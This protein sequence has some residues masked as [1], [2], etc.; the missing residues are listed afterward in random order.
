[1]AA[2]I[3]RRL[4]G[5]GH[6]AYFA[7]GCVR[8][9]LLGREPKDYD[10]ATDAPPKRVRELF[11]NTQ[12]VGEHFGVILVRLGGAQIEVA[13]FRTDGRYR[14][15]RR[16]E[17]VEFADA[18]ADA[19]RR[20]FTI[21]GLFY[22][23]LADEVIDHVGGRADLAA[24]VLRCIGDP[25]ERFA[26]DHLRLLR[27]VRF[28]A[29]FGLAIEPATWAAMR[30]L[31]PKLARITPERVGDELRRTLTPDAAEAGVGLLSAGGLAAVTFRPLPIVGTSPR[32]T[33]AM[34]GGGFGAR[35]AAAML[36]ALAVIPATLAEWA[37]EEGRARLAA[38][39]RRN[40]KLSNA[41][42]AELA[43]ALA[44]A[45]EAARPMSLARKKRLLAGPHAGAALAL[46]E[47]LAEAKVL[48]PAV[49]LAGLRALAATEVAP[50][51]WVTGQT[52]IAAGHRP[53][54]S[55]KRALDAA[56]DAQLENRAADAGEALA[57]A[58]ATLEP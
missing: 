10:V 58:L 43:A 28:A 26:E 31:A 53:G 6:V 55:F 18:E 42:E 11:R 32:I 30:G 33:A 44:L 27:A 9:A 13:T 34:R 21:N 48:R 40:L 38:V 22:D 23:P 24:G 25:I 5:G 56:Y 36:D 54:P 3:V 15:G 39:A 52:L 19:R 20:D 47:A 8:D 57:V 1:M 7:G 16:P 50:P 4:R 2:E 45:D 17:G 41:E 12:A 49:E 51:P 14:D 37:G 29:R 35:L 46:A